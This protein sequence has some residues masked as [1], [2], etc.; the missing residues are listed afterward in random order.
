MSY[1]FVRCL[2]PSDVCNS[3]VVDKHQVFLKL[4]RKQQQNRVALNRSMEKSESRPNLYDAFPVQEHT[5]FF[6]FSSNSRFF[7]HYRKH[8]FRQEMLIC[9]MNCCMKSPF[10]M[11][12]LT[13]C[14]PFFMLTLSWKSW[15]ADG[16]Y[17]RAPFLK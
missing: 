11:L 13:Q 2:Y 6:M 4:N 12:V 14:S 7:A 16:H 1:V 9:P 8:I 5:H 17:R 3:S 15:K 10:H